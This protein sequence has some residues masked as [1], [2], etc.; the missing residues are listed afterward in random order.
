MYT[1][2]F[3]VLSTPV[4]RRKIMLFSYAKHT[5]R[6]GRSIGPTILDCDAREG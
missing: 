3:E 2:K 6:G 5:L 1:L 4:A